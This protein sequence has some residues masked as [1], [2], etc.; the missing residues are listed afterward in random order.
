MRKTVLF[1]AV[2]VLLA[3]AGVYGA[4]WF[5]AHKA[6]E[7]VKAETAGF[8][9]LQW[10]RIV[11]GFGGEVHVERLQF[12]PFELN[13][14]IQIGSVAIVVPTTR[15]LLEWLFEGNAA[16]PPQARLTLNNA[17]L[18][19]RPDLIKAWVTASGD[20]PQWPR[21]WVLRACGDRIALTGADLMTMGLDVLESDIDLGWQRDGTPG[22]LWGEINAGAIGSADFKIDGIELRR[23]LAQVGAGS[24]AHWN[25]LQVTVRDGGF[26]RRLAAFCARNQYESAQ[27][28]ARI[29]SERL[30][31]ALAPWGIQAGAELTAL[32]RQWLHQGGA[33]S[34]ELP[35]TG[36]AGLGTLTAVASYLKQGGAQVHYNGQPIVELDITLVPADFVALSK[37]LAPA[38]VVTVAEADT[39]K[40]RSTPP[41]SLPQW[42][43]RRVQITL[44]SGRSLEGRLS[45]INERQLQV[46]RVV[47]GGEFAASANR[48]DITELAVWRRRG[49]VPILQHDSAKDPG[50]RLEA[51]DSSST[52]DDSGMLEVE[53]SAGAGAESVDTGPVIEYGPFAEEPIY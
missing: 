18:V 45:A 53:G 14:P 27:D 49:E 20:G 38:P 39:A 3:G 12:S 23:V 30:Q 41:E 2:V 7:R 8:G 46:A 35:E 17:H 42:L 19:L 6:L 52:V 10:G 26:M 28:W 11:P 4:T 15:S 31:Q 13:Q 9:V 48:R 24:L 43:E 22:S 29:E 34:V 21:P 16:L 32:Y 5:G 51:N 33:I 1:L 40:W 44:A 25:T 47:N 36:S 50:L 37:P